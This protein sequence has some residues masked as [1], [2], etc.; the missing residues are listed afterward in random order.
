MNASYLNTAAG[1]FLGV[2][3]VL[4]TISIAS[5]GIFHSAK[6][7]QEGFAIV[8]AESTGGEDAGSGAAEEL[9][10][11]APLLAQ[12][13]VAK[14]EVVFKKCAACHTVDASGT[15]K[16]GPGLYEIVDRPI[17]GH[18][19]FSYSGAMKSFA[20]GGKVWDYEALNHFLLAPKKYIPGTAM[21]FAGLKKEDE[22]ANVIAY[23]RTMAANPAP[24][25]AQ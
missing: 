21:G 12:A 4:M 5:E 24:L 25:P 8:A 19:G 17:A 14:G 10:P 3:F 20:E 11:I 9:A 23:L 22:R 7:E 6:P 2:V 16:V 13:D 1:A 18:E 15:N